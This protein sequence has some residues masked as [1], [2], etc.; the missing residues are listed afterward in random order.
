[1]KQIPS[2]KY[3]VAWFTLAECVSRGEKVRA[4]SLYRLLAHSIDDPAFTIQLKGDLLLA[5]QD[6]GAV[7]L[8]QE[9]A[10]L[11]LHDNRLLEAIG[12]YEHLLTLEP[13]KWLYIKSLTTLY[14]KLGIQ[15][16]AIYYLQYLLDAA[17]ACN[18]SSQ[19]IEIVE[20]IDA[21]ADPLKAFNAHKQ[22]VLFLLNQEEIP[23]GVA[24]EYG[25]KVVN[26]LLNTANDKTL[27]QFL[28]TV[29]AINADYYHGLTEYL[30]TTDMKSK[31]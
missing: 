18:D 28:N 17:C 23:M 4:L 21:S 11:Y 15:S 29:E 9:A 25:T 31:K 20:Q 5:F 14:K 30:N 26:Y 16:K 7:E 2:D 10:E 6:R 24:L 19:A 8:Y 27:Q 12:V 13:E 3:N 22:L 1:M